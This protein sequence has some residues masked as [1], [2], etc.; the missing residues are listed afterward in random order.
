MHEMTIAE[1]VVRVLQEQ[2]AVQRFQQVKTVWL[3]IGPFAMVEPAA[4]AF[5]FDAVT[6]DTLAAG[7]ALKIIQREGLAY[8][9]ECLK[10]VPVQRRYDP[11]PECNCQALQILQGDEMRIKELEVI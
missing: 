11:C 1:G 7:A 4:L 9:A 6:R 3:E 5:C 8:C 10:E 2:A